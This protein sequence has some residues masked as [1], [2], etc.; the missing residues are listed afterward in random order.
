MAAQ[1]QQGK[2]VI[3]ASMKTME[4]SGDNGT[5]R[6]NLFR[7]YSPRTLYDSDRIAT[8]DSAEPDGEVRRQET[9]CGRKK[10][11]DLNRAHKIVLWIRFILTM[12]NYH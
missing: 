8:P 1:R 4:V 10:P 9:K 6:G 3:Q 11:S 12:P 5:I 2:E 7:V